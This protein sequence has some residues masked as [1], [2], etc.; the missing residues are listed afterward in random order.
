MAEPDSGY[1]ATASSWPET[2]THHRKWARAKS[3]L[4]SGSTLQQLLLTVLI[5]MAT[6]TVFA[7]VSTGTRGSRGPPGAY[8]C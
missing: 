8:P 5:G 1:S 2:R 3:V 7:L 4:P 6:V